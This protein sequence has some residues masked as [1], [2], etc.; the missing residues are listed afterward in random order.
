MMILM[1]QEINKRYAF[2]FKIL[3]FY[4]YKAFLMTKKF[5]IYAGLLSTCLS[6]EVLRKLN[7]SIRLILKDTYNYLE[8]FDK[9]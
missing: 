9:Q 1:S 6:F 4:D 3:Q 7:L 2:A 8:N 5:M